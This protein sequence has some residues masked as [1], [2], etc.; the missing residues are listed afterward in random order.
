MTDAEREAQIYVWLDGDPARQ[1]HYRLLWG[2]LFLLRRL[3]A[4][5]RAQHAAARA[6]A[7]EAFTEAILHGDEAHRAWLHAAATAF[8]AGQPIRAL[9]APPAASDGSGG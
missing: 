8:I 3:L 7:I 6:Q 2:D 9:A 4:E 5:A 1:E